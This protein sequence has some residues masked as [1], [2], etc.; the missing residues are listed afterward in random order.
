MS[1]YLLNLL[2]C[3]CPSDLP[4]IIIT[5]LFQPYTYSWMMLLIILRMTGHTD[6]SVT[7]IRVDVMMSL[8][9]LHMLLM[10]MCI[11]DIGF[12]DLFIV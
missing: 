2:P 4:R 10:M 12:D 9:V 8:S 11:L 7:T 6:D 3:P 1:T 5:L